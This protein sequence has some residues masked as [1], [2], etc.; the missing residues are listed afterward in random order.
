M[1]IEH[2]F[3]TNYYATT[4]DHYSAL[5]VDRCHQEVNKRNHH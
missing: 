5:L 4:T 3:P 1:V 2:D